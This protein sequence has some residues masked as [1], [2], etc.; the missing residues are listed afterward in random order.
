VLLLEIAAG[1]N[2]SVPRNCR[3]VRPTIGVV[4]EIGPAHL[5]RFGTVEEVI[6]ENGCAAAL[7]A[8]DTRVKPVVRLSQPTESDSCGHRAISAKHLGQY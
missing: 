6:R 8:Q 5:E 4:T 3:I 7:G 1:P 2:G